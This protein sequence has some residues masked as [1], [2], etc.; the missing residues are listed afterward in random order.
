ML[1][2]T[3]AQIETT[4]KPGRHVDLKLLHMG[5]ITH[6]LNDVTRNILRIFKLNH[7]ALNR[8]HVT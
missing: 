4:M 6:C 2:N 5:L 1:A 8:A 7:E 3:E